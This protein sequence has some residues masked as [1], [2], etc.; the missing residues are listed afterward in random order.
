[1]SFTPLQTINIGNYA[2]DGTG[3]DLRT[4]FD[5][6]NANFRLINSEI[7]ITGGTN[8][9]I[10]QGIFAQKN[11]TNAQLEFKSLKAG[12]GVNLVSDGTSITINAGLVTIQDDQA[13]TLGGNLHLNGHVVI[14]PGD[15]QASVWGLDVREMNTR[16]NLLAKDVDLGS[17]TNPAPGG[18]DLGLF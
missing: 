15:V 8:I 4:A 13:P 3:D 16:L 7:V 1:M 9:G 6:V 11:N 2:N 18:F 17:F 10:G 5:K 14:G 12:N